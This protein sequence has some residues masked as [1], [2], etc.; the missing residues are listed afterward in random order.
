VLA[1]VVVA[2]GALDVP[3]AGNGNDHLLLRDEVL[4]AHIAIESVKDLGAAIVAVLRDDV[5]E[6]GD[7]DAALA[8]RAGEDRLELGDLFLEVGQA[9]LDL[10]ALQRRQ[11]A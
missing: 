8:L 1:A 7:D 2:A 6:F 10:L 11:S 3:T 4:D 5:A 9:I